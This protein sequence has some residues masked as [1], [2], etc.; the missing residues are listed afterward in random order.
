MR[1]RLTPF[2]AGQQIIKL[3]SSLSESAVSPKARI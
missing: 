1:D 3:R 2:T